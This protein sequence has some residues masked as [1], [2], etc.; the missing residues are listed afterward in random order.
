MHGIL[1]E[2]IIKYEINGERDG[3][4]DMEPVMS[5]KVKIKTLLLCG[6]KTT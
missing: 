4:F 6:H 3:T 5:Q 2:N 1:A